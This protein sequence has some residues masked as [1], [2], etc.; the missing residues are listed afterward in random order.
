MEPQTQMSLRTAENI[1]S[2]IDGEGIHKSV[3][4]QEGACNGEMG[5]VG[6]RDRPF[7]LELGKLLHLERRLDAR[8]ELAA[9]RPLS[10]AIKRS[11][12]I[13]A[14]LIGLIFGLPLFALI[15]LAIRLDSP[16][17]VFFLHKRPGYKGRLF[18]IIKFRTMTMDASRNF[19]HLTDEQRRE[20]AKYGKICSDPRVTSVG[21]WVRKFSLDE[22]PQLWNV[23]RGEMSL[24]GP[25]PYVKNQ[26]ASLGSKRE[27]IF[28]APPGLTGIWQVS[29]RSDVSFEE[30]LNLDVHYVE[31][32]SIWMDLTILIRT[33]WVMITGKGAY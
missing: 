12:D 2:R 16:G 8:S 23:F 19:R 11:F 25:R 14:S 6:A 3:V 29:G 1:T 26:V 33:P 30:R 17:P 18:R 9:D 13:V 32:W 4:V 27:I 31:N 7:G 10:R 5:F 28:R 21:Y 24:I 15:A 22:L 20:F